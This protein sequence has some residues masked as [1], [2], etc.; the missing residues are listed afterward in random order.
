MTLL[1]SIFCAGI[2]IYGLKM[3]KPLALIL[4]G[5]VLA[6]A[7]IVLKNRGVLITNTTLIIGILFSAAGLYIIYKQ[8]RQKL[9]EQ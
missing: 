9:T 8:S 6:A 4:P 1:Y 2:F 5:L 7:G 3:K